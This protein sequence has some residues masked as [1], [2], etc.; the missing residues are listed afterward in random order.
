MVPLGMP[1]IVAIGDPMGIENIGANELLGRDA[2]VAVSL[3]TDVKEFPDSSLG[4]DGVDLIVISGS[5]LGLLRQLDLTQRRGNRRL[6][7]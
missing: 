6:G 1:W 3:P 7:D 5:G 4:Y 2:T